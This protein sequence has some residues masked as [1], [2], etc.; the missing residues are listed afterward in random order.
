[1]D[2][3]KASRRTLVFV[4]GAGSAPCLLWLGGLLCPPVAREAH[5]PHREEEQ[6]E[7]Q[8]ESPSLGAEKLDS[9]LVLL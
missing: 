8:K 3:S 1:M 9:V 7:P 6:G 4:V 2:S 5:S